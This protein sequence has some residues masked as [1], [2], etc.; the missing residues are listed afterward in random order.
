MKKHKN[1]MYII[2]I[3]IALAII[4]GILCLYLFYSSLNPYQFY[5]NTKINKANNTQGITQG[6]SQDIN[7]TLTD[8]KGKKFDSSDLQGHLSLIYFG[9]TYSLYDDNALKK[10]EDIIK[11]LKK[12]NIIVQVVFITLDPMYDTSE[13][14]KE[15]LEKT[16][17]NF[18]GLTGTIE[19]IQRIANEFKVFYE[20]RKF[21]VKTGKYEL[22]HS[23]FVYLISSEG[24]FLKHYC[25]GLPEN[26]G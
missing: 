15:Y 6:I 14:L 21:D 11:I 1:Q 5:I 7:F 22:N 19:G 26:A 20:P 18:I 2:K 13:V 3:F 12:E 23:N 9:V 16:D 24:K 10:I 4:I 17:N 8:Q 25:L